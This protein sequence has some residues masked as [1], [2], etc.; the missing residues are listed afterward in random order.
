[1]V[2]I[3]YYTGWIGNLFNRMME[4]DLGLQFLWHEPC[5]E[6]GL[7]KPGQCRGL[8]MNPHLG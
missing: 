8:G 1:M 7:E 5:Y 2:A 6:G 4:N 3:R